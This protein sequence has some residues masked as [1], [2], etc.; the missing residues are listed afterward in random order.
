MILFSPQYFNIFSWLELLF[1]CL[2][3]LCVPK[4]K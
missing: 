2:Q 1:Q 4:T 3:E